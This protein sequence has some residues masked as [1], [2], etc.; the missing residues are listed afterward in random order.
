MGYYGT[1]EWLIEV[2]KGNV[3]GH[4]LIHKFGRNPAIGTSFEPLT[5]SGVYQMPSSAQSLE[6]V[7]DNANDTSAGTGARTVTIEGL[8]GNGAYQTETVSMNGTTAVSLSNDFLRVYRMY[9]ATGGRYANQTQGSNIGTITLQRIS[10]ATVWAEINTNGGGYGLGQSLIGFYSVPSG[11]TAY[12]LSIN[13]S[14][15]TNKSVD[16]YFVKREGLTTS[17]APFTP[18]RIQNVY[19]GLS[20]SGIFEH[21]TAEPYPA[22]TD[23]G[24]FASVTSGTADAAVEFELLLV[25]D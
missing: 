1:R 10:D 5:S 16:M 8:D 13:Y 24:F 3:A 22:G 11:K 14:V 6:I 2:A 7:S 4:S 9:V 21:R 25:D 15:D 23:I 12:L 18:M 17:S 19:E 20:G